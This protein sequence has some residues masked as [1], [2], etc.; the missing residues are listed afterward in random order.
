MTAPTDSVTMV[1]ATIDVAAPPERAFDVF[2]AGFD[3]WWNRE[4]HLLPGT[5]KACGIEPKVGGRVWEDND[6]GETCTWGRVLAWDP[7]RSFTFSWLI[8]A[9]WGVPPDDAVGSQ[10]TVTFTPTDTGTHVELVH[11]NLDNHGEGWQ[12]IRDSINSEGGWGSLLQRFEAT[13]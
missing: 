10:V 8:G 9:D 13:V 2:T 7:P 6:A 4:H 12:A 1:Q 11:D 3:G 5:L